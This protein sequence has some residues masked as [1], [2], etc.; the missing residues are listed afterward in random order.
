MGEVTLVVDDNGYAD[1]KLAW[2]DAE[3]KIQTLKIPTIIG[4]DRLSS[5]SGE[6]VDRY[7]ADGVDYT[8]KPSVRSPI[9]LRNANYP[10]SVENRVL[11]THALRKA[12]L[13][14]KPLHLGVTLSF[15]DYFSEGG[16]QI[17][18][19]KQATIANFNGSKGTVEV[20]G[21]EDKLN[22]TQVDCYSEALSAFFDFV[23]DDQ[24][25]F[26]D[27]A[28]YTKGDVAIIDIG[29]STT[30]VVNLIVDDS[31]TI[32]NSYSGTDKVGVLDLKFSLEKAIKQELIDL[33]LIENSHDAEIP[34]N[35]VSEVLETGSTFFA[36][37]MR[38]FE[39]L[40][41]DV[42]SSVATKIINNVKSRL[43]SIGIYRA[44]II[45]GGGSVV[46][47][48]WLT[49]AFPNPVMLDEFSN[50]RGALKFM[51]NVAA[52]RVKAKGGKSAP[53]QLEDV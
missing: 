29:G 25:E 48:H 32:N 6:T 35:L 2:L 13:L 46:F 42:A 10:A 52:G 45:T 44:I 1:H 8:C 11:V 27:A 17:T 3:G 37:E 26:T 15:R 49:K 38:N 47:H 50:A 9:N 12:K 14:N 28:K 51:R 20:I 43:G 22:I 34:P 23:M 33:G 18:E 21:S 7:R 53:K 41:D 36:G 5:N 31:I 19:N 30:D 4:T 39:V 24:G 40:R 16:A